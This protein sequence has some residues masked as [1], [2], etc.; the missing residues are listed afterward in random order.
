MDLHSATPPIVFTCHSN[1]S[2]SV[3]TVGGGM[4]ELLQRCGDNFH[5]L[6]AVPP[7]NSE[8]SMHSKSRFHFCATA[9]LFSRVETVPT[10]N[11]K[12]SEPGIFQNYWN[13]ENLAKPKWAGEKAQFLET[14]GATA[15]CQTLENA[16]GV[17]CQGRDLI[18]KCRN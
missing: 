16:R 12:D 13:T 14:G 3:C 7:D 10:E 4:A 18:N 2:F 6:S 17:L 11:W 9:G 15:L 8:S 5:F 1:S